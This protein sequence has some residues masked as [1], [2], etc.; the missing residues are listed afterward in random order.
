M[1]IWLHKLYSIIKSHSR[2]Y[3]SAR[4][5]YK[6]IQILGIILDTEIYHKTNHRTICQPK[7]HLPLQDFEEVLL[8][9]Q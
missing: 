9:H 2:Y 5:V 3:P 7:M 8:E 1:Y 6:Q 4:R